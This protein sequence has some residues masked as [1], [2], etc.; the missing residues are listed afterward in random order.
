MCSHYSHWF[1]LH[2]S[3]L[4]FTFCLDVLN[5]DAL[6]HNAREGAIFI[7]NFIHSDSMPYLI[8][9]GCIQYVSSHLISWTSYRYAKLRVAHAPGMQG[10][11]S[12]TPRVSDPD[13]HHGTWVTHVPWYM[14]G[15]LTIGL[16]LVAGKTFP[17]FSEHA[18]HAILRIW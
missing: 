8:C 18:Q 12:P 10:T 7:C 6:L 17:A 13:T 4:C 16:K 2:I 9:S 14:P 1:F 5:V 15:S 3:T 11:F